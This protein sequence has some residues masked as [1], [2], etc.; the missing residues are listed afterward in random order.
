MQQVHKAHKVSLVHRA[1][2]ARKDLRV[3]RAWLA[4]A[5]QG[6]LAPLALQAQLALR[7]QAAPLELSQSTPRSKPRTRMSPSHR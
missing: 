5:L 4:W 6:R 7:V 1:Q 3:H 2:S